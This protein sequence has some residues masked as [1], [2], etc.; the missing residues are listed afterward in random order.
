MRAPRFVLVL[1][2]LQAVAFVAHLYFEVQPA[3][4]AKEDYHNLVALPL[5]GATFC[6]LDA[7]LR[8]GW[9]RAFA[10]L[11]IAVVAGWTV[12]YLGVTRAL[13]FGRYAYGDVLGPKLGGVPLVIPLF[14]FMLVYLSYV[15]ANLITQDDPYAEG[16]TTW[17]QDVWYALLGGLVATAYDLGVDP[18]LSSANVAAWTWE[19]VNRQTAFFGVPSSNFLGWIAVATVISY[20]V[21]RL[22]HFILS[23]SRDG[24]RQ[25]LWLGPLHVTGFPP[26]VAR[27]LALVP[28]AFY[29]SFWIQHLSVRRYAPPVVVVSLVALGI[30]VMAAVSNWRRWKVGTPT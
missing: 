24:E 27:I 16:R 28:V 11:A 4:T 23:R 1:I 22:N 15:I 3:L 17:L 26:P 21:R 9:R 8:I 6:I 2:A 30:P 29:F 5:V 19:D 25:A 13:I 20:V 12:E 10:F 18:Y 14:W 7:M